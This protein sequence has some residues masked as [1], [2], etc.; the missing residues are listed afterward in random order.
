MNP[1]TMIIS[2]GASE[3]QLAKAYYSKSATLANYTKAVAEMLHVMD[4]GKPIEGNP[5]PSDRNATLYEKAERV[6]N[7]EKFIAQNTPE[8]E[9]GND[10]TVSLPLVIPLESFIYR[11]TVLL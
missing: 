7:F 6:V 8:P 11:S 5:I 4:T 3:M 1:D 10:I 2:L 9:I